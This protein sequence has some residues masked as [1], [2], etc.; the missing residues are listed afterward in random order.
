MRN[1]QALM[2]ISCL[3]TFLLGMPNQEFPINLHKK[4]ETSLYLTD[5][6]GL[7]QNKA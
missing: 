5:T 3:E 4:V 7:Y 6:K 2:Q 1:I